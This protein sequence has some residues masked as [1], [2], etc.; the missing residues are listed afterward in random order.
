MGTKRRKINNTEYITIEDN[1]GPPVRTTAEKTTR[2]QNES[3]EPPKKRTR[4]IN[5]HGKQGT[6]RLTNLRTIENKII[7][8]EES[9]KN[10]EWE[11]PRDWDKV[12]RERKER[13]NRE[14]RELNE[15]LE[16]QRR[17]EQGWQLYNL[18]KQ[19]LENNSAIWM[20]RKRNK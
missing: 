3:T 19:Q 15:Q 4:K 8:V 18:C 7:E 17:K 13:I 11:E 14:E 10:L 1:W 12:L 5:E 20:K 16:K 6:I 2:E 9:D